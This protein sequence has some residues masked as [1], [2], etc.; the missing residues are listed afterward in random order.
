VTNDEHAATI[1]LMFQELGNHV[2]LTLDAEI[3]ICGLMLALATLHTGN[4]E[5]AV[6]AVNTM[7]KAILHNLS[8]MPDSILAFAQEFK[9][10]VIH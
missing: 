5:E 3:V 2:S 1:R 10:D 6:D 8:T 4:R 9:E 7:H